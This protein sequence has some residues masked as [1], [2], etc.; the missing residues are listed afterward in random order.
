MWARNRMKEKK[1]EQAL[2]LYT[3]KNKKKMI[4]LQK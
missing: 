2:K 4:N 1:S 3:P